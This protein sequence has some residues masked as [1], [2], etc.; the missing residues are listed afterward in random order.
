MKTTKTP[1]PWDKTVKIKLFKD[2]DKYKDDLFV[3]LNGRRYNIKRGVEVELPECVAEIIRLSEKQQRRT[4]ALIDE[5]TS[6]G[7]PS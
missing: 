5:M 2:N 1:S 7:D 6:R 4:E 3:G